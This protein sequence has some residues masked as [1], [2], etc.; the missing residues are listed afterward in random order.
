MKCFLFGV[1]GAILGFFLAV[2]VSA[3]YSDYRAAAQS[4]N[5]RVE[6]EPA[7]RQVEANA[8]RIGG[9]SG[10]GVGVGKPRFS[11]PGPERFEV[12]TD[13]LILMQGGVAGQLVVLVPSLGP[14]GLSWRCL[15]G[16]AAHVRTC[17]GDPE[18]ASA[19][20]AGATPVS[21]TAR[22]GA[23]TPSCLV[24]ASAIGPLR[25]GMSL[26]QVRQALPQAVLSRSSDGDGAA[27][28]EVVVDGKPLAIA[29]AG[30]DDAARPVDMARA[31]EY[32]ETFDADCATA[33]G[34]H[35][36]STVE[37]AVAAYGPVRIIRR[38]EIES[39]EAIEFAR[40]P[41][42]L[43]FR[44]DYAGDFAE[45]ESETTR[46]APGAKLLSIAV[47]RP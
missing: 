6:V 36:G 44:L 35:P 14:E 1:L 15:G 40:Q 18:P 2:F 24:T 38:S 21:A 12:S 22:A 23:A 46:Y 34:I 27:L 45:G 8:A 25:P 42:A 32:L 10:A 28:V 16:S 13:G 17:T 43:R 20:T 19:D 5:W 37:A 3:Q 33:E 26:D 47:S 29:Y 9:L 7:Q 4:Y 41:P 30:E 11:Q 31:I 39:R